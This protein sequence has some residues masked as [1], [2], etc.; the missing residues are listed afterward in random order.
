[1]QLLDSY[2]FHVI[3]WLAKLKAFTNVQF[4]KIIFTK[5]NF[6]DNLFLSFNHKNFLEQDC[7]EIFFK[8]LLTNDALCIIKSQKKQCGR[9]IYQTMYWSVAKKEQLKGVVGCMISSNHIWSFKQL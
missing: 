9:P 4:E 5:K 6:Y 7:Y 2:Q 3:P 8:I 1:M